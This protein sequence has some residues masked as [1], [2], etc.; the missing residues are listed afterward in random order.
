[1][2]PSLKDIKRPGDEAK[3]FSVK[4]VNSEELVSA[5]QV[6]INFGS[7]VELIT[8][9]DYRKVVIQRKDESVIIS[10]NLL[11]DLANAHES[12]GDK[13]FPMIFTFGL[14]LGVIIAL[15]VFNN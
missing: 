11:T 5:D 12:R 8:T 15:L 1:M 3:G 13:K 2:N 4:P 14:I 7:F 10:S 9:H 6:A